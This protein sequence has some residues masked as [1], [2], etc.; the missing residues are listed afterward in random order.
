MIIAKTPFRISF[1]GGG[2]DYPDWF[3]K[4]GGAV[5]STSI[6]K[7]CYVMCRAY[8]AFFNI[9]H[10]IIWSRIENVHSIHEIENPAVRGAMLMLGYGDDTGLEIH[11]HGDLPARSGMG[12]SSAFAAGLIKCL[13]GLRGRLITPDELARETIRLEQDVLREAVGS[14]D[15]VAVAYGGL[16][17]IRFLPNGDIRV[18]PL[19]LLPSRLAALENNLMLFYTGRSRFASEVAA[20]VIENIQGRKADT[21]LRKMSTLVPEALSLLSSN[22]DLDDFGRLLHANWLLKRELSHV[23]SNP[24]IDGL[25]AAALNNGALGGKL[26][27]AGESGF[28]LFYVPHERQPALLRAF[29]DVLRVPFRFSSTG[30]S[31][32]HNSPD[33]SAPEP[34]LPERD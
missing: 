25:Y 11:Y 22:G 30:S 20:K 13:Y 12:S 8:P 27:G 14:Q 1:F 2:T 31:I 33:E 34:A 6:D 26:L 16:N 3:R 9:K 10:R 29:K 24:T 21:I 18:E 4:E 32:I 28:M 7:Y 15:Q 17:H 23:I 19:P 5:L